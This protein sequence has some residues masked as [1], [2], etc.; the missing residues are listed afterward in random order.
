MSLDYGSLQSIQ[1]N[2]ECTH[3]GCRKEKA[4]PVLLKGVI[5]VSMLVWGNVI[6]SSDNES[7]SALG[8][9]TLRGET[10]SAELPIG[11]P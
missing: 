9:G 3:A 6:L 11:R 1:S 7:F 8:M 2:S 10:F 5:W 4:L